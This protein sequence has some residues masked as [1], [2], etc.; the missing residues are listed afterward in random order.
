MS[1]TPKPPLPIRIVPVLLLLGAVYTL[2]VLSIAV[3]SPG[4]THSVDGVGISQSAFRWVVA[5]LVLLSALSS[6]A[7]GWGI[8]RK[9]RWARSL[10]FRMSALVSGLVLLGLVLLG[11]PMSEVILG[12]GWKLL[13]GLVCL[14]FVLYGRGSVKEYFDRL[15]QEEESEGGSP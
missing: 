15:E 9:R 13:L 14:H 12:Y 7:L 5:P 4:V 3:L 10:A 11:R 8:S 2:L 1:S 6:L